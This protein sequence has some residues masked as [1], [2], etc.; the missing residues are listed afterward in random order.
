MKKSSVAILKAASYEQELLGLLE[1]GL[2]EP[3]PTLRPPYVAR[4]SCSSRP[5]RN[6]TATPASTPI[7]A[8]YSQHVNSFSNWAPVRSGLAKAQAI[9]ATLGSCDQAGY[10]KIVDDF[11]NRFVD[12]N[13]DELKS[14]RAYGD[15]MDLYLPKT[16]LNAD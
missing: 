5:G 10:R 16:V 3:G 1:A 6:S 8:S 12:L 15:T 7:L 13:L 14:V 9:A 4:R 2:T 11:D